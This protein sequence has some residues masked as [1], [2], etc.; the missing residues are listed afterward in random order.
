MKCDCILLIYIWVTSIILMVHMQN[1]DADIH[2]CP[3][4]DRSS[5]KVAIKIVQAKWKLKW[6]KVFFFKFSSIRFHEDEFGTSQLVTCMWRVTP[7]DF[8]KQTT[9]MGTHMLQQLEQLQN[10]FWNQHCSHIQLLH[11]HTPH[12][13]SLPDDNSIQVSKHSNCPFKF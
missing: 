2:V 12:V 13:I 11:T 7:S 10:I 1:R 3:N 9:W 4:A 8:N 6:L 5:C